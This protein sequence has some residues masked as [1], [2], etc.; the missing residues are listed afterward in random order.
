MVQSNASIRFECSPIAGG[1][2]AVLMGV[3]LTRNELMTVCDGFHDVLAFLRGRPT[4]ISPSFRCAT[5]GVPLAPIVSG[6][7]NINMGAQ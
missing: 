2:A 6:D 3:W 5:S 7:L 4:E 1:I